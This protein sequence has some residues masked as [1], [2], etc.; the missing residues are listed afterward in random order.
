MSFQRPLDIRIYGDSKFN[1]LSG[2]QPNAQSLW[3]HLL[4]GRHTTQ[5][6]GY[7]AYGVGYLVDVF[8]WQPGDIVSCFKEIEGQGMATAD[9]VAGAVWVPGV[10]RYW[11]P[12][13]SNIGGWR[14]AFDLVPE[15]PLS[16]R[17]LKGCLAWCACA[18]ADRYEAFLA[19][20]PEAERF[21]DTP[22]LQAPGLGGG[23]DR[24]VTPG[25]TSDTITHTPTKTSEPS[26]FWPEA[27]RLAG[28]LRG[29]IQ[30]NNPKARVPKKL[31]KWALEFDRAMRL[32]GRTYEELTAVIEWSQKDSFWHT[33]ILSAEAVRRQ[34][35][36]LYLAM[37]PARTA[38]GADESELK[39]KRLAEKKRA[40]RTLAEIGGEVDLEIGAAPGWMQPELREYAETLTR[41]TG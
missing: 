13:A 10:V 3:L 14:E 2:P 25:P 37:K 29:M 11:K 22:P 26:K 30:G 18:G 8:G 31:D 34:Y 19:T 23:G 12:G 39:V 4:T 21:V 32:D 6:A 33:N 16:D 7:W 9:W 27:E 41:R 28:H 17:W 38:A 15:S 36:R 5:V 35:D 1:N 40:I 24:G 20:F